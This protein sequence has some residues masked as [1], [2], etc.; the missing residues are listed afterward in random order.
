MQKIYFVPI[1]TKQII[2]TPRIK[3]LITKYSNWENLGWF[4][5][6]NNMKLYTELD[7]I[8]N[9]LMSNIIQKEDEFIKNQ[10][11]LVN[12]QIKGEITKGKLRW[13]GIKLIETNDINATTKWIE[14]RGKQIGE[15]LQYNYQI[16]IS[17]T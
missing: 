4:F 5:K 1:F 11:K 10:L 7:T 9:R 8:T 2:A 16:N 14:Q 12:P 6:P 17:N 3:Y 13:R 15:R